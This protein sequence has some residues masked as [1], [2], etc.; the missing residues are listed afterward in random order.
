MIHE[1]VAVVHGFLAVEMYIQENILYAIRFAFS[2]NE[3]LKSEPFHLK[4][5]FTEVTP[6]QIHV[7]LPQ[8]L[9][10]PKEVAKTIEDRIKVIAKQAG[11]GDNPPVTVI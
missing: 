5:A 4:I 2:Q 9:Y 1:I 11:F 3:Q 6:D 7:T 10:V 8:T